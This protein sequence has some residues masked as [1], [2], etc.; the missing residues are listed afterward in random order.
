[1]S[2]REQEETISFLLNMI[3]RAQRGHVSD[4]L[5]AIGL[6]AGQE[7]FL[8][9]LWREDGLAQSQMVERMCVQPPTVSKMLDRMEK[10]G[11][12]TRRPDPDDSRVTR[13]YLTEQGR[14][15]EHGVC[16]AWCGL[17]DRVTA[18]LS[19]EERVLLRRL[20]LQVRDNL[21]ADPSPLEPE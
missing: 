3:C 15:I 12:V 10:T 19:T 5:A 16:D 14:A 2:Y 20:L 7:N 21:T 13:V 1:V 9:Q 11:L 17:E 8:W 4:S 6:Y 18:N